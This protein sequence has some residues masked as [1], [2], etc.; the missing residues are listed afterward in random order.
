[1]KSFRFQAL[2]TIGTVL[3]LIASAAEFVVRGP[4]RIEDSP[5]W[6]DF[7]SPYIQSI[8]WIHGQDPY[9]SQNLVRFWP[10]GV[11][12]PKF[13]LRESVD[14]RLVELRG[15][16]SPYPPT[17][18]VLLAPLALFPWKA[19]LS[20]WIGISIVALAGMLVTVASVAGI[21]LSVMRGWVFLA[22]C[23][24]LAPLHTGLAT[25]NPAIVG[26][27]LSVVA[28]WLA[29]RKQDSL[30]GVLIAGSIC[31]KPP[32]GLCFVFFYLLSRRWKIVFTTCA[33]VALFTLV[34]VGRLWL[35]G[36]PW[37]GSY[38]M[39]AQ[40]L[41]AS[42]SINDFTSANPVWF[43]MVNLQGPLYEITGN[44]AVAKISALL[45]G[46]LL[47]MLWTF[48]HLSV[49]NPVNDLLAVG[50]LTVLSLLPVYHR[51]Y[52]ASLL[53]VPI[54]WALSPRSALSSR[55]F[56]LTIVL[57][58]PF[59]IPGAALLSLISDRLGI[60]Q[61]TLFGRWWSALVIGHEAWFLVLLSLLLLHAMRRSG[62][63]RLQSM[64]MPDSYLGRATDRVID[65]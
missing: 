57:V 2:R 46:I 16:P 61:Q 32:I 60:Q 31:L 14:N 50:A 43:Q 42:G 33:V 55:V 28:L 9:S 17:S 15:V 37:V 39:V 10:T 7:I 64:D 63:P 36:D 45:V 11:P 5:D 56:A 58:S 52:D 23:L 29:G 20:V 12:M 51:F 1:M 35:S 8:A 30:A 26:V 65:F 3:L 53:I 47:L 21:R 24:G 41:F 4:L 27:A 19:A 22:L 48:M 6:N 54:A 38:R 13:V 34:A 18:F 59:L 44:P 62:R 25:A 49:A 40:H